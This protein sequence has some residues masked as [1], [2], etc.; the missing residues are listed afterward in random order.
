MKKKHDNKYKYITAI[1]LNWS[2]HKQIS[3]EK[4]KDKSRGYKHDY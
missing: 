2:K 4:L 1:Y 3:F